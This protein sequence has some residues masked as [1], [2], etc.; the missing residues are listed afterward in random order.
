MVRT[1]SGC[2]KNLEVSHDGSGEKGGKTDLDVE[3]E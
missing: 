2:A 3:L 1:E